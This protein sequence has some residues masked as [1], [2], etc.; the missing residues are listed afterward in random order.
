[1][2][3]DV[4]Y[5]PEEGRLSLCAM[6]PILL[7]ATAFGDEVVDSNRR[8]F[9]Y[10]LSRKFVK[11]LESGSM[12]NMA[13][14]YGL[15]SL[16]SLIMHLDN[17]ELDNVYDWLRGFDFNENVLYTM[18]RIDK[19]IKNIV[20]NKFSESK[21][22]FSRRLLVA[23]VIDYG[24]LTIVTPE[25]KF[26]SMQDE[27]RELYEESNGQSEIEFRILEATEYLQ[28]LNQNKDRTPNVSFQ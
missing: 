21:M 28:E 23:G 18:N 8:N 5:V 2:I 20:D 7:G 25:Q 15:P 6:D 13:T 11:D 4:S 22:P 12:R 26:K 17:K 1:M 16:L 27:I 19:R 14:L 3:R 24:L 9:D 10:N